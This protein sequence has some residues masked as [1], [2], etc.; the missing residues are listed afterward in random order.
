[1]K[2]ADIC[3]LSGHVR[4]CVRVCMCNHIRARICHRMNLGAGE[5]VERLCLVYV[6]V[7]C[8]WVCFVSVA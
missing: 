5:R 1:M 8:V 3:G 2:Y 7:A 6:F 4:V